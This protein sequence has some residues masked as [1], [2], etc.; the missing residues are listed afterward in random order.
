[1]EGSLCHVAVST[2]ASDNAR[3]SH[4]KRRTVVSVPDCDA[5][6]LLFRLLLPDE[7]ALYRE[8][9]ATM[10]KL[11]KGALS[12]NLEPARRIMCQ[13]KR[14]VLCEMP[15][16]FARMSSASYYQHWGYCYHSLVSLNFSETVHR[17]NKL[18]F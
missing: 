8:P 5:L 6:S 10:D 7:C 18:L 16:F 2:G 17:I 3:T 15:F 11:I 12:Y 14:G 13:M 1:M 4:A 9:R